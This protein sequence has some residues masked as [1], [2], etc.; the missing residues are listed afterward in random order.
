MLEFIMARVQQYNGKLKPK[1]D[2]KIQ[3]Q[4]LVEKYFDPIV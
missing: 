4:M 3:I 2:G 1:I